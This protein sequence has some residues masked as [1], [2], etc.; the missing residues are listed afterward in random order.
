MHLE[1][2]ISRF[3]HI[4]CCFSLCFDGSLGV[5]GIGLKVT[6]QSLFVSWAFFWSM[7]W[8]YK[9]VFLGSNL[10]LWEHFNAIVSF[11]LHNSSELAFACSWKSETDLRQDKFC[12]PYSCEVEFALDSLVFFHFFQVGGFEVY[13]PEI[14]FFWGGWIWGLWARNLRSGNCGVIQT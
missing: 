11:M 4:F 7:M 1:F 10:Y 8:A 5:W 3:C 13:R 14:V 9:S 2:C 6:L 12:Y